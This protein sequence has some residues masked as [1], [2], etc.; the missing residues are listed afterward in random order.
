MV[1]DAIGL[2][3]LGFSFVCGIATITVSA[4]VCSFR[5]PVL[6]SDLVQQL[7]HFAQEPHRHLLPFFWLS[8]TGSSDGAFF[9]CSCCVSELISGDVFNFAKQAELTDMSLCV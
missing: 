4:R 9:P 2:T 1:D 7:C 8:P 3:S 5:L 6:A